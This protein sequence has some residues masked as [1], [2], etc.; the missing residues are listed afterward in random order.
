MPYIVLR[1]MEYDG[2]QLEPGD[3]LPDTHPKRSLVSTQRIKWVPEGDEPLIEPIARS[4]DRT[5]DYAIPAETKK[6][7]PPSPI[8]TKPRPRPPPIE[9]LD[10]SLRSGLS[11]R[12]AQLRVARQKAI[13]R[14]VKEMDEEPSEIEI[15][16]SGMPVSE[17]YDIIEED[18]P[19]YALPES[20]PSGST[21][22]KPVQ[23]NA[24]AAA[25]PEEL[26]ERKT[27]TGKEKQIVAKQEPSVKEQIKIIQSKKAK[28]R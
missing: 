4:G 8:N 12:D 19:V 25:K 2:Q 27:H 17:I 26:P 7:K 23:K 21:D 15:L 14:L 18:Q 10:D 5:I 9:R 11:L 24:P 22:K 1:S 3:K 13:A 28:K 20:I 16:V 6:R